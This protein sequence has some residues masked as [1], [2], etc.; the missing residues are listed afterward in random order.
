MVSFILVCAI[1]LTFDQLWVLLT[2]CSLR[3][4]SDNKCVFAKENM[5]NYKEMVRKQN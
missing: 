5:K 4:K 2:D 3:N 1:L